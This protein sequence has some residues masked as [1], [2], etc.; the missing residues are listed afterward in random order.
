MRGLR[1]LGI[2]AE[3]YGQLLSS[4]LMNKLP[5]EMRL[6]I[7]REL[8]GGKW[9]VE[10]MMRIIN[11][12]V[13]ARERSTTGEQQRKQSHIDCPPTSSTFLNNSEQSSQC[14]YCGRS[15]LSSSCTV[16]TEVGARREVLRRSGRCYSCL[17]KKTQHQ[18]R[19]PFQDRL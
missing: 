2:N 18:P 10:E 4:I 5:P 19:L 9:N 8:G 15:H 17:K 11:R 16:V 1:S 12:E 14:V 3:S 6:I 7:S 13:D